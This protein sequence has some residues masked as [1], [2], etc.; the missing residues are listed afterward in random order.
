MRIVR[1]PLPITLD[2]GLSVAR[3]VACALRDAIAEGRLAPGD[4]LP[5]SRDLA[6]QL[7]VARNTVLA[8]VAILADE[9]V[10]E[11]RP[12]AGTFVAASAV[13]SAAASAAARPQQAAPGAYPFP[14]TDWA[15]R[16][17]S[18]LGVVEG[19]GAGAPLDFRPGLPD[20]RTIPFDEWRRSAARKLRTLR[21][22]LGS[23]GEAQ[24][25]ARLREEI[26]RYV[27]RSRGVACGVED[28]IVTSGAQQALDLVARVL[29][30]PG[31]VV[32]LEDPGYK[33]AAQV[34]S[35]AGATLQG[36]PVDTEGLD[37]AAMPEDA[38]MAYVTPSHQY[39]LGVTMSDA[40][41]R[42]L[43]AWA[44]RRGAF[45]VEDDYDS[46]YRYGSGP[47]PAL[48]AADLSGR[49]IYVGTFSKNLMPGI[50]LGYLIAPAPLR[51]TLVAAK[52]LVDRHSDNIS[53]SVL[54]E[55]MASGMFARH[56]ARMREV[57]AE[58]HAA[59][60]G[61][62]DDLARRGATLLPSRAGLHACIL[63]GPGH[64]EASVIA[65][66]ARE[67]VGLY[68]LR[69][70]FLGPATRAGFVLGF[71]NIDVPAIHAGMVRLL[72]LKGL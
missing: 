34:F 35:A 1:L 55:F 23:Y 70:T 49:V 65:S 24:G 67:G 3:A 43:L 72:R 46:E 51:A 52:W 26:A 27:A 17:P 9:G 31:A 11:T 10:V 6:A 60:M 58:R 47:L 53:Q 54:A 50:R 4:A 41:R 28:V 15:R 36:V 68:G 30:S 7:G 19:A 39:P 21:A 45:V 59:L 16:L 37:V 71:G 8:A 25:D 40:R 63:L 42:D 56:V 61:Y 14:L 29:L 62:S 57:Y 22:R 12:A 38:A 18:R 69:T 44:A 20:L 5:S 64:D 32:A 48:Q 2:A 13:A 66:A 33:L